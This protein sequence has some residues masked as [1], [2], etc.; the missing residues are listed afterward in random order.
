MP[1]GIP[2]AETRGISAS[3]E[4]AVLR[5]AR[6]IG[7]SRSARWRGPADGRRA[8]RVAENVG[9]ADW[10]PDGTS[11]GVVA[12]DRRQASGWSFPTARSL[13]E[14][15]GYISAPA[16][17]AGW[18]RA[19][20]SSTI[21]SLG[22]DRGSVAVVDARGKKDGRCR[23]W[24][25]VAG[26]AWSPSGEE[27]WFTAAERAP[28]S[29]STRCPL[30]RQARGCVAHGARPPDSPRHRPG[31]P[32][33]CSRS[34]ACVG[35]YVPAAGQTQ[36]RDL[37][38]LDYSYSS[39]DLSATD[40]SL[41]TVRRARQE[42]RVIRVYVRKTDGSA[43]VRLGRRNRRDS[44]SPDGKWVVTLDSTLRRLRSC[45]CRWAPGEPRTFRTSGSAC[46]TAA[47]SCPTDG[48][49]CS[50]APSPASRCGCSSQRLERRPASADRTGGIGRSALGLAGRQ[51][52][53]SRSDATTGPSSTPSTAVSPAP[54]RGLEAGQ[55][56]ARLE[57]RRPLSLSLL[58]GRASGTRL[59]VD[60]ETGQREIWREFDA[61]RMPPASRGYSTSSSPRTKA[62]YA[63]S[64]S[65]STSELFVVEGM[66]VK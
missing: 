30:A 9:G 49:S 6:T 41:L 45:S 51:V 64:Y 23:E 26:L 35:R 24:A 54:V 27:I 18:R 5:P 58:V 22:D 42:A 2:S 37:S 13:Y 43:A 1:L 19:S 60:L 52:R 8:P 32:R 21:R 10:S 38:W 12:L 47:A 55:W 62:S 61:R 25:S 66:E 44:F 53:A 17:L 28:T 4:M 33:S 59:D 63:Y 14:T 16:R 36:E 46:A 57:P 3:G 48:A 20:R 7:P 56:P 39:G 65:R 15:G 11:L 40:R 29:P 34:D 50:A 31:R